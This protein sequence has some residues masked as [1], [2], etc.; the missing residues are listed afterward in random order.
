MDLNCPSCTTHFSVPD[1]AIGP[2]GRKLKCSQCGHTWRQMPPGADDAAVAAAVTAPEP[3]PIRQTGEVGASVPMEMEPGQR[4]RRP[5]DESAADAVPMESTAGRGG[6]DAPADS[7]PLAGLDFDSSDF[8]GDGFGGGKDDDGLGAFSDLMSRDAGGDE[9][10]LDDLLANDADPIPDIFARGDDDDDLEPGGKKRGGKVAGILFGVVL[11]L[12]AVAAAGWFARSE[13]VRMLPQ[14]EA[15]Y[16]A[17]GV[18]VDALGI[19]LRFRNVTSER[20]AQDGIDTLVVRG[21]IAN[22]SEASRPVP[23]LRLALFDAT[24]ALIQQMVAQPP[25]AEL[26]PG[27]TTGFRVALENPSAAARRFEVDWTKPPEGATP[28]ASAAPAEPPA[29]PAQQA[30]AQQMPAPGQ[31]TQPGPTQPSP[32]QPS[33]AQPSQAPAPAAAN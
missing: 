24:D 29:A 14:S 1:G 16:Q 30:P 32:T 27:E 31:S 6:R 19:G 22:T 17:L 26:G 18:P 7:D 5:V 9:P 4:S 12:G 33:P 15:V 23:Y 3:P 25:L 28:A 2:K 20:L 8:G 10:D 21:F 13:I 11:V